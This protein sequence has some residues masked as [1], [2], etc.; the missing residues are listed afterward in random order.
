M[1]AA[2]L[3][4][5]TPE[6]VQD[7][8]VVAASVATAVL[9]FVL[10]WSAEGHEVVHWFGG[11]RPQHGVALGINFAVGPLAAGMCAV[12]GI[13]VTLALLYTHAFLRDAARLFDALM[14]LA[15]GAM[16]GFAMSGDLFNL[17]VWLELM[18]VAA[19][20]LTGYRIEEKAPLQ[21][22]LNFAITNSLGGFMILI[23]IALVYGHTGALNLAQIGEALRDDRVDGWV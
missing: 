23:G 1:A 17:F 3:D 16:C 18:G 9:A 14:L 12:I 20:A 21:G 22:A 13:V 10:L 8:L 2:G 7:A 11:W 19:Y 15:L 6:P 4:H 5:V